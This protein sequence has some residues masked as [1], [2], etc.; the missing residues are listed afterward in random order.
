MTAAEF[1]LASVLTAYPQKDFLEKTGI[2]GD[3]PDICSEYINLFDRGKTAN[4]LYETEYGRARAMV[5]GGA[6]VDIAGFY[7]A[8]GMQISKEMVDHISVELE[9][10][11]WLLM[12]YD[13]LNEKGDTEGCE[14]VLDARRKFLKEHLAPFIGAICERPGVLSSPFY[15]NIFNSCRDLVYSEAL[16]L[17]VPIEA[18]D[19]VEGQ[20]ESETMEC[21]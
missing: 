7:Q 6:L 5:K 15:S 21:C 8:F 20:S 14:I 11:A 9:F 17:D 18:L 2:E 16:K 3:L 12:K 1:R 13:H 4:P 19:W 10:Y